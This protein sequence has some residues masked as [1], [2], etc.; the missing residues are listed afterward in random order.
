MLLCL[1]LLCLSTLIA[2]GP[3]PNP[4]GNDATHLADAGM[5][6]ESRGDA[7]TEGEDASD[8]AA[9]DAG[10][11][12]TSSE[13]T[14]P[15]DAPTDTHTGDP[16]ADV[17]PEDATGEDIPGDDDTLAAD[18]DDD[19]PD[20][21]APP[22]PGLERFAAEVQP[23][24]AAQCGA[25]HL[26]ARFGFT[27][28]ERA[29]EEFTEAE[30][31]ANY[32][33]AIDLLA[34]D[35]P[36][37]SRLLA[38][39]LP[40]DHADAIRHAGPQLDADD[41]E[42]PEGLYQTALSW[43]RLERDLRCPSC[44]VEA[45]R[46]Y[47][48]YVEAPALYWALERSP[49]RADY[50]VRRGDARI[51][52]QPLAPGTLEAVGDPI[53]FLDGQ[54]C[55]DQGEC[56]F[57]HLAVNHAGDRMV[58]ECRLPVL[59]GD[60]WVNDTNWN[61]C[62]AEIGPDGRALDPRFLL[63]AGLRKRGAVMARSSPFGLF[64]DQ[65]YPI[66]GI[67][68]HHFRVRRVDD[69]TPTFS[70]DDQWVY[71][72]SEGPEPRSG[73][74]A[75]RTYHGFDLVDN[76]LAYHLDTGELRTIYLNDGG[77]ADH[78]FFLRDGHLALHVW[79]LERMD[80]HLYIR[81]THDGMMEVPTLFGRLQGVNMWGKAVQI[82]N[83]N[84]VGVT[85]RRR[86]AVELWQPFMADHTLGTGF[87]EGLTSYELL[88]P[89]ID[90]HAPHFSYCREPPDGP[91]CV[92][93][94]F[95]LDPAWSPDGQAFVALN[96]ELTYVNQ[97]HAM[98]RDYSQGADLDARLESLTPYLPQRMGIWRLNHRGARTPVLEPTPGKMLR[99]PAW[100]GPRHP[101]RAHEW[102]TDEELDH[103]E[104]HIANVPI[105]FGFRHGNDGARKANHHASLSRITSLRVLVKALHGND[106]LNDGRPY[107]N[108]VHDAHDHP[109]HLG[110]SNST[111]YHRLV[112]PEAMGG[113]EW[114]DVPLQ[115]DGSVKLR[116][117]AGELLLFQG[118]DAQGHVVRQHSRVF[119]MPPGHSVDTSVK[120]EQYRDQCS[121]CHG[122][123]DERPFVGLQA[124]D[125]LGHGRL[126][127][128]TLAA[129]APPTDLT[130]V[131]RQTLT[132]KHA[133]RPMFDRACV[134]CHSGAD[135][136]GG[137]SLEAD[138]STT[139]NYPAG[140]L[141]ALFNQDM[142]SSIPEE[143]RVPGHNFSA[144]YS[145]LLRND[146]STYQAHPQYTELIANHAPL[147][148]LAPWDP[149]YQNLFLFEEG[150][151]RY[152]GGDGYVSHYG[153]A[154][155]LGGNSQDAWLLEI[156]GAGDLNARHDFVGPDH[157]AF[158]SERERRLLMAV[159]DVGFPYAARCDDRTIPTGPNAG[160]P[161]G[162]PN[163]SPY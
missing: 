12:A 138:Y 8:T 149:A 130:E 116:V 107:R 82:G 76:L 156:L 109:T 79:N 108:A 7:S 80:R 90:T 121:S 44:G 16:S 86:G 3:Q 66:K 129:M 120:A 13:D 124:I 136:A 97:G 6:G 104:L 11:D 119:A 146:N 78:P 38:K 40:E 58:F 150:G 59:E 55:N 123:L 152:L 140:P 155:R 105:W 54:L 127:M 102:I 31:L 111:G 1:G 61:I 22:P 87:E 106:C 53:D 118:V 163:V 51:M 145:W 23:R 64:N 18:V 74:M 10:T 154:D 29:G 141:S 9:S 14:G 37:Q 122:A 93:D 63:P 137:L 126:D 19:E 101:P 139:A 60:D 73:E 42:D 70:P 157:S 20:I 72:S 24:I 28:F 160:E 69:R 115:P 4:R 57:G 144:P 25:C 125:T 32:E 21:E 91:N 162:D 131:E 99:Y 71:F 15:D 27:T 47:L 147:A 52:L 117:P 100:V 103:A 151:A 143:R 45:P 5:E 96:P 153:R 26:G 110:I 112:V 133:L 75:S 68:D 65:G 161:W 84:I 148:Q 158:L 49:S 98:F 35:N 46:Q 77:T 114:G 43:V 89:A 81:M 39:I 85:G 134:S 41:L 159:M 2:C 34:L 92:V 128:E 30:T 67:Y 33:A 88:D 142:L 48:A 135:P 132:F 50:G 83:G 62:V 17:S 56:D 95:Y 94:R 113:D 36:A